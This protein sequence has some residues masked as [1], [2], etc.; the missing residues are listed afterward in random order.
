MEK[1]LST[2]LTV[3]VC[4]VET[5]KEII[6]METPSYYVQNGFS[7]DNRHT[8]SQFQISFFINYFIS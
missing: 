7:E 1:L 3:S 4:T 2:W 6:R 5:F 8:K